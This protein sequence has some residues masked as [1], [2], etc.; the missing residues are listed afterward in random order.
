MGHFQPD[1]IAN[2]ETDEPFAHFTGDMSEHFVTVAQFHTEHRSSEHGTDDTI[3]LDGLI[4]VVRAF[5]AGADLR[6]GSTTETTATGTATATPGT[7]ATARTTATTP[8][9]GTVMP[10]TTLW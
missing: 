10:A 1:L 7:A 8:R 5:F 6:R 4:L 2:D 3:K 9:S